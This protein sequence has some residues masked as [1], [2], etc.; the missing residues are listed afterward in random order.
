MMTVNTMIT[1]ISFFLKCFTNKIKN[2]LNDIKLEIDA[3]D[4]I[5]LKEKS[6]N[7][8]SRKIKEKKKK[9]Q[10]NGISIEIE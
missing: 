6:I 1:F 10:K 5:S 2:K 3:L 4:A 9:T 7:D 8:V